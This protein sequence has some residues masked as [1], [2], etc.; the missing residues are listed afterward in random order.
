MT[1]TFTPADW[2]ALSDRPA[3]DLPELQEL[4]AAPFPFFVG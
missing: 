3:Q 1:F 4:L 2:K